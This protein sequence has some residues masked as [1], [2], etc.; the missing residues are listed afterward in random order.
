MTRDEARQAAT[1]ETLH[2]NCEGC[3]TEII[4]TKT[5]GRVP[6]WCSDRC[7][8]R[9]R[10]G[11]NC[12]RCGKPDSGSDVNK[13]PW[14]CGECKFEDT[15]YPARRERIIA[16]WNRGDLEREISEREGMSLTGLN[17]LIQKWRKR[18]YP[19]QRRHLPRHNQAERHASVIS[20]ASAG[21][22]NREI[23]EALGTTRASASQMVYYLR[24]KGHKIPKRDQPVRDEILQ[25]D[26][27]HGAASQAP[28]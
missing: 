26:E 16:A 25:Q 27:R 6:R 12:S 4:W 22:S 28:V 20:M 2:L 10:Y 18:G 3:G 17:S 9:H 13:E 7:R 5:C 19:I 21:K 14:L 24:S 1:G 23:A 8:K 15:G 11:V